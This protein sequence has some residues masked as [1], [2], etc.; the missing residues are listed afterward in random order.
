MSNDTSDPQALSPQDPARFSKPKSEPPILDLQAEKPSVA[1]DAAEPAAETNKHDTLRIAKQSRRKIPYDGIL[2]GMLGGGLVALGVVIYAHVTNPNAAQYAA[3]ETVL[4]QKADQTS[5][6]ALEKRIND[7]KADLDQALSGVTAAQKNATSDPVLSERIASL[8]TIIRSL[9]KKTQQS[10]K[11]E[12]RRALRL[13]L[14]LSLRDTMHRDLAAPAE[15]A[16]LDAS[17]EKTSAFESLKSDLAT[18]LVPFDDLRIEILNLTKTLSS[19]HETTTEEA[20]VSSR[21]SSFFSQLVTVRPAGPAAKS[22]LPDLSVT[23]VLDAV[24]QDDATAALAA[25]AAL[26]QAEQEKFKSIGDEL[27]RHINV[28]AALSDLLDD[29]LRDITKKDTP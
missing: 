4:A 19:G 18:P 6:S 12:D 10:V 21:L 24:D 13:A 8:E 22:L 15:I 23:P 16:A 28:E 29:A 20:K 3:L 1:S 27:K 9:D 5:L 26:P 14:I 17:G 2:G 11:L 25:L 7:I